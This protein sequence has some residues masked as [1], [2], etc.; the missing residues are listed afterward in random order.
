MSKVIFRSLNKEPVGFFPKK[1][2]DNLFISLDDINILMTI[3]WEDGYVTKIELK[4]I[5]QTKNVDLCSHQNTIK[6]I[7]NFFYQKT[8]TLLLPFCIHTT[9]F[10]KS[11]YERVIKIPFAKTMSY[12]EIS[13]TLKTS[14][15]A[16]G[17]AMKRNPIPLIIP[18]HR[19]VGKKGQLTGFSSGLKIKEKLLN[20]EKSLIIDIKIKANTKGR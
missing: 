16:I 1:G 12:K 4:K 19:V 14:P 10:M 5:S 20:F 6:A 9:K 13:D 18:C 7:H 3:S 11:V 17:Q 8:P 2:I 15:R